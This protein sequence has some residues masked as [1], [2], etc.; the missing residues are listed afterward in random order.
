MRFLSNSLGIRAWMLPLVLVAVIG[1]AALPMNS[2]STAS[3]QSNGLT[4][5]NWQRHV[6]DDARPS[7]AVLI[8]G[9]DLNGDGWPDI[10]TGDSWYVNPQSAGGNWAR[11]SFGAPLNNMAALY[12]FD[13]D[14]KLDVLGNQGDGDETNPAFVWAKND[15]SG[16]FTLFENIAATQGNFLQG[17]AV[18]RYRTGSPVQVAI[19]WQDWNAGTQLLTVPA[20][21]VNDDWTWEVASTTAF[22]E[23]LSSGDIDGNGTVDLMLGT[24]WL[25]NDGTQW[26]SHTVSDPLPGGP[27]RN[28]LVDI[29]QDGRLDAVV[30]SSQEGASGKLVWYEQPARATDRWIAHSISDA[31]IGGGMS[32]DAADMDQDGDI[33]IVLGEHHLD[34]AEQ[35][36]LRLIIFEN[37]DGKGA[38]WAPHIVHVGD[39]HHDGTRVIDIDL[40]GDLDI[41]SIGWSHNR[42]LLYENKAIDAQNPVQPEWTHLSS[43]FGDLPVPSG[44]VDQTAGLVLDVDKDGVKDFVVGSRGDPGDSI[45]WYRRSGAGWSR[46]VIEDGVIPIEAGGA[47]F[48]VDGDGDLDLT[49]GGDYTSNGI[50]WWENPYPAYNPAT[51]WTKH[52]IKASGVNMH[53]DMIYGD[54]D[55]NGRAELV[56]WNQRARQLILAEIP[57]NPRSAGAWTL[58][59]IYS[60]TGEDHEGLAV[61]DVDLD[62]ISDIVGGGRWFK[63]LSGNNYSVNLIDDAKRFSRTAVGQLIPGGR[64][65]VILSPAET[66]GALKWYQWNGSAWVG[67]DLLG[68]NVERTHSLEI[69]DINRDGHLDIF[70]AEMRLNGGNDDAKMWFFYGD[71][72]GTFSSDVVS[73]GIGNHESRVADLDGDGD[74]DI[75]GKPFNWDTPRVDVWLNTTGPLPVDRWRRHVIDEARPWRAIFIEPGDV[76]GDQRPDIIAGAWWYRNPGRPDGTWVRNVIGEPLNNMAAVY[77]FDNDGA[78]DIVGTGGKGPETNNAFAWARNDGAGNFTLYENIDN[79]NGSF[80]QGTTVN[81]FAQG[82]PLEVILSWQ[83]GATGTQSLTVPNDPTTGQWTW[84]QISPVSQGEGLDSDDMDRDGDQDIIQGTKWLRNDPGGWTSFTLHNPTTGDPDR[85]HL[86][87]MDQDGDLD[88]VVGYGH[89][90]NGKLAWY[91][92]PPEITGLWTEHL[93]A[94]LVNPQSVDVAD[95][96]RDGDLDIVVGEH[97]LNSPADSRLFIYENGDGRGGSWTEHMIHEGDEHHDGTQLVDIDADGD[98]DIISTGWVQNLVL[99]YENLAIGGGTVNLPPT[100]EAGENQE[101]VDQDG[102]GE[103]VVQLDGSGSTDDGQITAYSWRADGVEIASGVTAQVTLPIGEHEVTLQVTDDGETSAVDSVMIAIRARTPTITVEPVDAVV[104]QG[105]AARFTVEATGGGSL[106]Y[107]WQRNGVDIAGADGAEYEVPAADLANAGDSYQVVVSNAFGTVTSEPAL[108]QVLESRSDDFN[109]CGLNQS[110]WTVTDPQAGGPG[111]S[112]LTVDG[113]QLILSVPGGINHDVWTDGIEAPYLTV[114]MDDGNLQLEAKFESPVLFRYQFQGMLVLEDEENFVRFNVQ[115]DGNGVRLLGITFVDGTP[116]IEFN[117]VV[118]SGAAP[119]YLRVTRTGSTWQA[120]YSY[121]DNN[122]VEG[123]QFRF[124]HD[125]SVRRAGLFAGN[126]GAGEPAPAFTMQADYFIDTASPLDGEDDQVL[127]PEELNVVATPAR[128]GIVSVAPIGQGG[129]SE[130]LRLTAIP[131]PGW[132]FDRW[133]GGSIDGQQNPVEGEFLLQDRIEARFVEVERFPLVTTIIANGQGI[134]GT[135]T[136]DPDQPDYLFDEVVRLEAIPAP[137]WT[138]DGWSEDLAGTETV[139]EVTMANPTQVT[140]TFTQQRYALQTETA[141]QGSGV[142]VATPVGQTYAPGT[143]VVLE[144]IAAAGSYFINWAGDVSGESSVI[145]LTIDQ[146]TTV[147]AT[148]GLD[149]YILTTSIDGAGTIE[150][151]PERS[152]FQPGESVKLTAVPDAGWVFVGW[153]GDVSGTDNPLTMPMDRNI[154]VRAIFSES[155]DA[156]I[157]LPVVEK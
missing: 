147:V 38:G 56:F 65:E 128:G 84:R 37:L 153:T 124:T 125:L 11:R 23:D 80:L 148:F 36:T 126:V 73:S 112:T 33:D 150:R 83:N 9:G 81:R 130:T 40:D 62:G 115:H 110:L 85:V 108:L 74:L 90:P 68:V 138:F 91:E 14:S 26:R 45:V 61:A 55:G 5:D 46:Y 145:E 100:A 116:T 106:T 22:G 134:G 92:R 47:V 118:P 70:A 123:G 89:D 6:I 1:L 79:G 21:P 154:T 131:A 13:N 77:D 27:D 117:S 113:R 19:S 146:P 12:D 102:D 43:D 155:F 58:T 157:F 31:V 127:A 82:G 149:A 66:I 60:Y 143:K 42:V 53:H 120:G 142:I 99:V 101:I 96:D 35:P 78:L 10:A 44:S 97:N 24:A 141:G 109:S 7:R 93:I 139:Q 59:P 16:N 119:F 3:G 144:A 28:E 95:L 18:D 136:R 132:S 48:D 121:D 4:L 20:D 63:H 122:W 76:D 8:D 105:L 34:P 15:G 140:A 133:V 114:P 71:G 2:L 50:W 32:L 103:E 135:V 67:T 98:L 54:F 88:A 69:V 57:D 87:D 41:L 52:T 64:V 49:F 29:N 137:G 151:T 17:V 75:F 107:Q 129:C 51:S 152:D 86:V 72:T 94:N 30:G 111:A 39:E 104:L 156:A 25:R